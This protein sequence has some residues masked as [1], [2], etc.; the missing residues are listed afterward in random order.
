MKL[1]FGATASICV[2]VGFLPAETIEAQRFPSG[3][4]QSALLD[5]G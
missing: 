3:A 1:V 5:G 4:F 2:M